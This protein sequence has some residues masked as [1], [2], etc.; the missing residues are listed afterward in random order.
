MSVHEHA[1]SIF[2]TRLPG[3]VTVEAVMFSPDRRGV[4]RAAD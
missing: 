4:E 3:D 1:S 2:E